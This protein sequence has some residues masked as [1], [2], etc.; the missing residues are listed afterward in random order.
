MGS[1][2]EFI[3]ITERLIFLSSDVYM[4][5][6]LFGGV[7]VKHSEFFSQTA[8]DFGTRDLPRKTS[9]VESQLPVDRTTMAREELN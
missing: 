1:F 3:R 6:P 9:G 7:G 8:R 5:F 4:I 2:A